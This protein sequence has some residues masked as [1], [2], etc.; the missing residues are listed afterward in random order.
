MTCSKCHLFN[1]PRWLH[2][3]WTQHGLDCWPSVAGETCRH[4]LPH[5]NTPRERAWLSQ[6]GRGGAWV[7]GTPYLQSEMSSSIS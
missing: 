3:L 7:P 1:S 4:S 2:H 5:T 6:E